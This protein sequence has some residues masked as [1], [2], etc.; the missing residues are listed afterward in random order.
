MRHI[1]IYDAEQYRLGV[2]H[3]KFTALRALG[4]IHRQHEPDGPGYWAL[5]NHADVVA[6]GKNPRLFSSCKGGI[7]IPDASEEDLSI[8][9]LIL[10]TM[11]P[12]DHAKYRRLVSTG[13]TPKMTQRLEGAIRRAVSVILDGIREREQ[14]D[15]VADIASRLPLFLIADL[16]GWPEAD[17]DKMF[18]WSNRVARIDAEPE[19]AR[20]AAA[21]FWGYCTELIGAREGQPPGD[22]LIGVLLAAEVDGDGLD[23]M[24]IV[25][26][27][28][29]LAIGGNETTRNC[30]S[31]GFLALHHYPEQLALLRSDPKGRSAGAVEEML[32]WTSP[33]IAF[34][35]TATTDTTL[36]GQPIREG[37]KVVLYYASANRDE[38]VFDDPQRFDIT[39]K[40]N[41]H[42]AFGAGQHMCLGATL[43][44]MEI[45]ILFEELVRRYPQMVPVGPVRRIPCNY[46][47]G[48][49]SFW[50]QPG[51]DSDA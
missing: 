33:I 2:P 30:I 23:L 41:P 46:F 12:P 13:F 39:R 50:A 32:R 43:A 25:N 16:I 6:V 18:D 45:G 48:I 5:V 35:R 28:L 7:N 49:D 11:D 8:G 20:V 44:R 15:F 21:E 51:P 38:A 24:Q 17:R 4:P 22:D 9:D 1:D 27:L 31:G 47:N 19:D 3:E 42:V 10:I 36:C 26:F 40:H 29:L 34:R 37:E 14:I